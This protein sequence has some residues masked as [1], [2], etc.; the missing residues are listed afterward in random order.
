MSFYIKVVHLDKN[1]NKVSVY[2]CAGTT[3]AVIQLDP[4]IDKAHNFERKEA[5]ILCAFWN[6]HLNPELRSRM[7]LVGPFQLLHS[8]NG[9]YWPEALKTKV[10]VY[11]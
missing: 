9:Q 8:E 3:Q 1:R 10:H 5:A 2:M 11:E 7:R 4:D 6:S